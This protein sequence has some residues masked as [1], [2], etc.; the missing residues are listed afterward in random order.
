[1]LTIGTTFGRWTVAGAP[2]RHGKKLK[3]E[4]VCEC[5][6]RRLVPAGRSYVRSRSCGCLTRDA[7]RARSIIH[8]RSKNDRTYRIWM[9]MRRRCTDQRGNRFQYY[10]GRGIKVC[11][12]WQDFALFLQ[13][14]GEAPKGLT[15]DRIDGDGHYEPGNCRWATYSVQARNKKACKLSVEAARTAIRRRAEGA[16]YSQIGRELGVDSATI[17][18]IFR[19]ETWR[20][21]FVPANP[22]AP[23]EEPAF[24][25]AVAEAAY[26]RDR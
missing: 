9:G 5:G 6:T 19:G 7:S 2:I 8:G 13:D 1:M 14:M 16:S 25:A 18:G 10:G 11:D 26:R 22:D 3:V 24:R 12:R 20:D 17:C 4:C 15:L 21:A 23:G